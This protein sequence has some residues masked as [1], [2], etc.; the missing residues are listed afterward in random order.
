MI[1][2]EMDLITKGMKR[3]AEILMTTFKQVDLNVIDLYC[4]TIK[5]SFLSLPTF[6]VI[7]KE[8]YEECKNQIKTV[9]NEFFDICDN[10]I[11]NEV[12]NDSQ[13]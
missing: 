1:D 9:V 2:K 11:V 12:K 7:E 6:R 13:G 5:L 8:K 10:L 3:N 4:E